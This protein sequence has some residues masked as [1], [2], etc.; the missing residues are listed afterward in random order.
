MCMTRVCLPMCGFLYFSYVLTR[1]CN[2]KKF[3]FDCQAPGRSWHC[4]L[5][6]VVVCRVGRTRQVPERRASFRHPT[7]TKSLV[8]WQVILLDLHTPNQSKVGTAFLSTR[9]RS[10]VLRRSKLPQHPALLYVALQK[11]I[12]LQ[13]SLSCTF[14]YRSHSAECKLTDQRRVQNQ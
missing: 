5:G 4:Q 12:V 11:A 2:N 10:A 13:D 3:P 8:A 14:G 7:C 1:Y 6:F 9:S